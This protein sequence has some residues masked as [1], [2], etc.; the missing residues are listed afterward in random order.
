MATGT[1]TPEHFVDR[2]LE[3]LSSEANPASATKLGNL[4][5]EN[6][7]LFNNERDSIATLVLEKSLCVYLYVWLST[8]LKITAFEKP[9]RQTRVWLYWTLWK[10]SVSSTKGYK[11]ISEQLTQ[12]YI[13]ELVA[14]DLSQIHQEY[15][16]HQVYYYSHI[17][18][19]FR[20]NF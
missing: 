16:E 3:I 5:K 12:A 15:K 17:H 8:L 13:P 10:L 6:Q 4:L 20:F 19:N 11:A 2:L 14:K 1:I 9:L 18:I 7:T